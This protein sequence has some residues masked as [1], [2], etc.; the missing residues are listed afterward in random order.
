MEEEMGRVVIK[1]KEIVNKKYE[2]KLLDG[3]DK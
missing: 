1:V 3:T 2:F